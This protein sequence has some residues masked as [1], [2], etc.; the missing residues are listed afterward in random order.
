MLLS[1]DWVWVGSLGLFRIVGDISKRG[2]GD[3][4]LVQI[5]EESFGLP[6]WIAELYL[7]GAIKLWLLVDCWGFP[8]VFRC[9]FWL[10]DSP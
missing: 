4:V 8:T 9:E 10:L 6:V 1:L 3:V 2:A 5:V 7:F